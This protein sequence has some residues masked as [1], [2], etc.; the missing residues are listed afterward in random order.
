MNLFP[1]LSELSVSNHQD[2]NAGKFESAGEKVINE[3]Q[4]T[5]AHAAITADKSL[6]NKKIQLSKSID[7]GNIDVEKLTRAGVKFDER[8]LIHFP[9]EI[10]NSKTEKI[11]DF[12]Y[13]YISLKNG[14]A[15]AEIRQKRS[16]GYSEY[17]GT[18][19]PINSRPVLLL[20]D[21]KDNLFEAART[22]DLESLKE[23]LSG[24]QTDL[25]EVC[26]DYNKNSLLHNA[27]ASPDTKT[28]EYLLDN[29]AKIE[30]RDSRGRTPLFKAIENANVDNVRTLLEH[31]ANKHAKDKEGNGI[32]YHIFWSLVACLHLN[33]R[34]AEN[35][36]VEI[37]KLLANHGMSKTDFAL[38]SPLIGFVSVK[39]PKLVKACIECG[40]DVNQSNGAT[41]PLH[42]AIEEIKTKSQIDGYT[43]Y[44]PLAA[45]ENKD[46]LE[47][48]E[49]LI[50]NGAD[51]T[52]KDGHD[53]TP[54]SL[55]AKKN[56]E[57]PLKK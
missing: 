9:P 36:Y 3:E 5:K 25:I 18:V 30:T 50:D 4:L 39:A 41:R 21:A 28:L 2:F 47:M 11:G 13:T 22:G 33:Q 51:L 53:E 7:W 15:F 24:G 57:L 29:G 35:K 6:T 43:F 56:V 55:A 34:E 32:L 8:G 48:I 19:M 23:G 26:K 10:F 49:V 16:T 46:I 42:H 37:V 1:Q 54:I 17:H 40:A 20:F 38:N 27:T 14:K 45:S 52:L 44:E 31:G 12:Q